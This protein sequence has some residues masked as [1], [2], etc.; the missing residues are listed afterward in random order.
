MRFSSQSALQHMVF[1]NRKKVSFSKIRSEAC[2][3]TM[4]PDR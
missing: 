3:Q 4:L 1:E 2:G